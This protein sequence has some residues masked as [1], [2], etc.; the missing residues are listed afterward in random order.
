[1][2]ILD[3]PLVTIKSN[4]KAMTRYARY[5]GI[6]AIIGIPMAYHV[7]MLP[8]SEQTLFE[9]SVALRIEHMRN[10]IRAYAANDGLPMIEFDEGL[11]MEDF[12]SDGCHP[13]ESGHHKM[14]LSA[15]KTVEMLMKP[16]AELVACSFLD[17]DDF[18]RVRAL[19]AICRAY[20]GVALKLELEYK[21]SVAKEAHTAQEA[22]NE[23]MYKVNG[24]VVGYA[25]ICGFDGVNLEVNGMV[26]PDYRRQG[27]FTK[28][29]AMVMTE[30]ESRHE[31]QMLLL[32]DD[33]SR[34]GQSF[35][36][37]TKAL[38]KH[39]EY[40]MYLAMG[41]NGTYDDYEGL[42]FR[43]ATNEDAEII[44][45]QNA[46]YFGLPVEEVVMPMPET[47]EKRGM[48]M[49]LASLDQKVIGKVNLQLNDDEAAI[50]GLGVLPDYRGKGYGRGILKFAVSKALSLGA[51]SVMLQVES[52]NEKALNLYTKTGFK[53]TSKMDYYELRK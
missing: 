31:K 23:F 37:N 9:Q 39:S 5:H 28:L 7:E 45:A 12:L 34:P 40:E 30:F 13:N 26:H 6:E 52:E 20:D 21:A 35:V 10:E 1:D 53:V 36:H 46:I 27:I 50:Y 41:E 16:M 25:G 42:S 43:K 4:I 47:E 19:E 24:E 49:Y 2:M 18:T 14:M 11:L 48:T 38:Y 17:A 51:E 8:E 44:A 33:L 22:K 3:V 32:C 29:T 15:K